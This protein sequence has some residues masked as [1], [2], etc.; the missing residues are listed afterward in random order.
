MVSRGS[1]VVDYCSC[2]FLKDGSSVDFEDRL[3]SVLILLSVAHDGDNAGGRGGRYGNG[4]FELGEA[5][6]SASM[7]DEGQVSE[8]VG[9]LI[10]CSL[11]NLSSAPMVIFP[12]QYPDLRQRCPVLSINVAKVTRGCQKRPDFCR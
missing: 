5:V 9:R 2:T 12:V 7:I 6:Q 8:M 1:L 10:S 11:M 4:A 3:F